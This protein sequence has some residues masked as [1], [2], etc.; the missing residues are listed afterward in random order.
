MLSRFLEILPTN[1]KHKKNLN[2]IFE[3]LEIFF[4]NLCK[5][6]HTNE[7]AVNISK[8]KI[9]EMILLIIPEKIKQN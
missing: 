7:H 1:Q 2:C 9:Y 5:Q 8:S 3:M 6:M 4:N